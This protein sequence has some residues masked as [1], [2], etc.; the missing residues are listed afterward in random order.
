MVRG[1]S[2]V[3]RDTDSGI[4]IGQNGQKAIGCSGVAGAVLQVRHDSGS[5]PFVVL[6]IGDPCVRKLLFERLPVRDAPAHELRPRR[7]CHVR[8]GPFGQ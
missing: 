8:I 1:W 5:L 4:K 7:N 6:Q 2:A 3:T